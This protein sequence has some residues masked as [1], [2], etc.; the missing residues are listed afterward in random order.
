MNED[1]YFR[2]PRPIKTQHEHIEQLR[3]KRK[4]KLKIKKIKHI[5]HNTK[6]NY[7]ES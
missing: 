3:K 7:L 2:Q 4:E 6:K 5:K 1:F